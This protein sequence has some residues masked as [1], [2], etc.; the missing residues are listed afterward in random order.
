VLVDG[1]N[2]LWVATK[3]GSIN[4]TTEGKSGFVRIVHSDAN[5][6]SLVSDRVNG[7]SLDPQG[8]VWVATGD[9]VSRLHPDNLKAHQNSL[10]FNFVGINFSDAAKNTYEVK[11]E[12]FDKDWRKVNHRTQTEY[13]NMEP[14]NYTFWV[15]ATNNDGVT[16]HRWASIVIDIETPLWRHP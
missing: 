5:P 14:G 9:G 2:R 3:N 15:R 16:G 1:Q 11:L 4:R 10:M 8:Y 12:G 6:N 7:F 13:T